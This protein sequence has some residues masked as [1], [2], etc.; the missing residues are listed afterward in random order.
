[1]FLYLC[2][3]ATHKTRGIAVL[4]C[5]LRLPWRWEVLASLRSGLGDSN[6]RHAVPGRRIR[7]DFHTAGL[8]VSS[9]QNALCKE[10]CWTLNTGTSESPAK[11]ADAVLQLLRGPSQ[12][13]PSHRQ[14]DAVLPKALTPAT[15]RCGPQG[16][17]WKVKARSHM[18]FVCLCLPPSNSHA[19]KGKDMI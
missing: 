8:F 18:R 15:Y 10:L 9:L 4:S 7:E 3:L 12:P 19:T 17:R 2:F 13:W 11:K 1:M 16:P 6:A 5:L 14:T